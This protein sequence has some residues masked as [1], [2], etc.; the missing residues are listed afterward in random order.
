MSQKHINDP[1]SSTKD[2]LEIRRQRRITLCNALSYIGVVILLFF[3]SAAF[4]DDNVL[5]ATILFSVMIAGIINIIVLR[6]TDNDEIA[7]MVLNGI[8][9]VLMLSL[10]ITG[11]AG[12][13]GMLWIYPS[14][15]INLFL[16]R[17]WMAIGVSVTF[18]VLSSVLLFTPASAILLTEYT[19]TTMVRFEIAFIALCVICLAAIRAE[20]KAHGTITE[21]LSNDIHQLAYFDTLTGLPNR[22]TFIRNLDRI[23]KRARNDKSLVALLYIDLDNFKQINDT[24]GHA[25]G[26]K[27][28]TRVGEILDNTVRPNDFVTNANS[29]MA[30]LAGDEFVVVLTN[31]RQADDVVSV[32]DRLIQRFHEGVSINDEPLPVYASIGISVYPAD[33]D[34][35]QTLLN[36]ADAA[37]NVAKQQGKSAYTFFSAEIAQRLLERKKIEEALIRSIDENLFTL[38]LMPVYDCK[39]LEIVGAEVLLRCVNPD[40]QGIGPDRFIP[41]AESTGLIKRIDAWVLEHAML[42]LKR[43]QTDHQFSGK[44]CIN[45]SGIELQNEDFPALVQ[46]LIEKHQIDPS[47]LELEITETALVQDDARANGILQNIRSLGVGLSL[48]DFGTGYT[49]FSQLIHYPADTLKI[50]RSFIWGLFAET[51]E[52][53]E[54]VLIMQK[55]ARLYHLRVIAE[56]VE[57]QEQLEYLQ[58]IGCEWVQGYH[59]SKP[60][61]VQD[62]ISLISPS[63]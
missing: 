53:S 43:M 16:N 27:V 20:E 37:M 3:G 5:L 7:V 31:I 38:M 13:T 18:V 10:L 30:R 62:F 9:I 39:T 50:D 56:G 46:H 42:L 14:I 35:S 4:L 44:W 49:A 63:Q 22:V 54:M 34:N 12:N 60:L 47:L 58:K 29:Q 32:A 17:F 45:F 28:L 21:I 1:L 15:A 51:N 48:D 8:M 26:D 61:P 41:V 25:V 52:T 40:M 11:G 33:A 19:F 2:F 24:Y 36:H 59:L 55:L 57:T 6:F 23:L